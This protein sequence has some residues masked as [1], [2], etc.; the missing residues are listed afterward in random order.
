MVETGLILKWYKDYMPRQIKCNKSLS[1]VDRKQAKLDTMKGP[2]IVLISGLI[3][4]TF[5][6][7]LEINSLITYTISYAFRKFTSVLCASCVKPEQI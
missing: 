6:F 4:A 1:T 7:V 5:A 3:V 2:F